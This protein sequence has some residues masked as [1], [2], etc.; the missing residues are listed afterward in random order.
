MPYVTKTKTILIAGANEALSLTML[1]LQ[2]VIQASK[3]LLQPV[4]L[5]KNIVRACCEQIGIIMNRCL[6]CSPA[7]AWNDQFAKASDSMPA[8]TRSDA[9]NLGSLYSES[10]VNRLDNVRPGNEAFGIDIDKAVP[11]MNVSITIA[12]MNFH[13]RL[14]PRMHPVRSTTQPNVT[15]TKEYLEVLD[16]SKPT[17]EGRRLVDLYIDPTFASNELTRIVPLLANEANSAS[18]VFLV[19]RWYSQVCYRSQHSPAIHQG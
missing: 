17:E 14:A 16:L 10:I 6:G 13:T 1:S 18:P 3:I 9:R 4:A 5:A 7:Q 12:I 11:D 8:G 2:R 15:Y 19:Q